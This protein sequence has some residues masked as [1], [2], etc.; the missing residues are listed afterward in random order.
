MKNELKVREFMTSLLNKFRSVMKIA[1]LSFILSFCF[2]LPSFSANEIGRNLN[3]KTGIGLNDGMND[4]L[5][6]TKTITGQVVDEGGITLPGV[7]VVVKGTT[8]GTITDIDGKYSLN[9]SSGAKTLVFSF[10]GMTTQEIVINNQSQINVTLQQS[11]VNLDEVIA[12]GYGSMER[13]NVTGAISSIKA[14]EIMKAPVP[15]VVEALRGQVSGVKISRGSGQPGSGVE[16]LIR[17][18]KSLTSGN[19]PLIVIDGVPNTGGNIADIN[20][21]DIATINIL[22]DAAAASIYGASGANGVVL[23]TT[24]NG[25]FGKPAVNVEASYG[26]VDLAMLPTVFNGNEY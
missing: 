19:E 5:Q 7:S 20:T 13:N 21:A 9:V 25:T 18:K 11:I 10:V 26:L 24:K 22:K 1:I 16:F 17:G 15:N 14:D 2:I 12:I 23:I 6:Q 3:D 8:T 4:A